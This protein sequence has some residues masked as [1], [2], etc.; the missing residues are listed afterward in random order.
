[1]RKVM[2]EK[3]HSLSYITPLIPSNALPLPMLPSQLKNKNSDEKQQICEGKVN[4][5]SNKP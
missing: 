4:M 5:K 2:I 1:M 3:I